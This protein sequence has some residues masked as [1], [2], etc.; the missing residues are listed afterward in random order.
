EGEGLAG[1]GASGGRGGA[2]GVTLGQ[3]P[4]RKPCHRNESLEEVSTRDLRY[5]LL[6]ALL[7]SLAQRSCRGG[8]AARADALHR[9]ARYHRDY[10]RRARDYGVRGA[11]LG[12][13]DDEEEEEVREEGQRGD[14]VA[15]V[16]NGPPN[17]AA[18]AE[19]RR[20]KIERYR[21]RKDAEERLAALRARGLGGEGGEG[22]EGE[23]RLRE[24]L[25]LQLQQWAARCLD[26][27]D[28]IASEL[29]LLQYAQHRQQMGA[30]SRPPRPHGPPTQPLV[31][32]RNALQSRVLGLGYPARPV[33]SVQ[34]WYDEH[35]RKGMLPDQ[36]LSA[37]TIALRMRSKEVMRRKTRRRRGGD[38]EEALRRARGWDEWKDT[39]RRGWGNRKNMG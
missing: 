10:L 8:T 9:S 37:T 2:S 25:L 23:E 22:G 30:P 38:D 4:P 33:M 14:V 29:P 11:T 13:D 12:G 18:M 32:T 34:Q 19:R 27:L 5:L 36:G 24:E 6:P 39:H 17:L 31:L 3:C 15:A 21:L 7:G 28:S 35:Q 16:I 26:D 20:A 1:G